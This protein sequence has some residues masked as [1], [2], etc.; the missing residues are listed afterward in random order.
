MSWTDRYIRIPW[1]E[2][3]R[4]EIGADCW[5]LVRMVLMNEAGI[6]VPAYADVGWRD[7][8]DRQKLAD[9]I[10]EESKLWQDVTPYRNGRINLRG[11]RKYDLVVMLARGFPI[12]IGI[13]TEPG[14]L[15][16][17]ERSGDSSIERL[18]SIKFR[19]RVA[20]F[21]RHRDLIGREA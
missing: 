9:Y 13:L 21:F 20:A 10:S 12:H 4:S 6:E 19:N 16:H 2:M 5:G 3:G 8:G 18:D 15:L 11:G 7:R 14:R 17:V 1:A